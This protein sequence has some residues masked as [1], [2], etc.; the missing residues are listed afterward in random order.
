LNPSLYPRLLEGLILPAGDALL[1]TSFIR[2][3]KEWRRI[4]W[5]GARDLE[6]LQRRNLAQVL[7]FAT[8]H[9]AYYQ[10]LGLRLSGDPHADLARFPIV[11]KRAIKAEPDAFVRGPRSRL[12]CEKSS[13][14]SGVQGAVY[15]TKDEVSHAQAIQTL[16]WEWAGFRL[17]TRYFQR[18]ITP[19]RRFVKR[20]KDILLRTTYVSAYQLDEGDARRWLHYL[21]KNPHRHMGGYASSL[22]VFAQLARDLGIEDIRFASVISWGD[23]LFPH[24]R[25]S[26]ERQF[27]CKVFDTYGCTEGLMMAGQCEQGAYHIMTPH[28][29][30]ELLDDEDR[31]V[32][33][34]RM[35][36]VVVTRLD[37]FS[38]PLI[39]YAL[40]DLAEAAD[41]A[42]RCTCGRQFPILARVIGR[43]T[44]VVKTPS[45]KQMIVHFFTG[46]MEHFHE[47]RQFRV[48]QRSPE[49]IEMEYVPDAGFDQH[50]LTRVRD[51]IHTRLGEAFPIEFHEV[52]HIPA[53]PSGKPEIVK[54]ELTSHASRA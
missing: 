18:G 54:R 41:S 1:G 38:M 21:R 7:D 24:Y 3:L 36:R 33:P 53:S 49:R 31:P 20:V 16:W 22:Y 4:Q 46:I 51:T 2:H 6:N 35:G 42:T 39:R 13:G 30:L 25:T 26:I 47:I 52:S 29:C 43:E 48:I 12:V 8:R 28:V 19:E 44:D 10:C 34:G 32:P 9:I 14:S 45:G 40:G 50:V 15:M 37:N 11:G 23:K 5:L 27:H 17:G